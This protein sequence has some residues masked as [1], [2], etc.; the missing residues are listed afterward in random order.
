MGMIKKS[1]ESMVKTQR[2]FAD[3]TNKK[4][5]SVSILKFIES[6]EFYGH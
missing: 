6:A 4:L 2:D 3:K 5:S 1:I